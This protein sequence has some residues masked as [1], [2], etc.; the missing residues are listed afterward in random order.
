MT[1]AIPVLLFRVPSTQW[2]TAM[3]W[4]RD[5]LN[6]LYALQRGIYGN[7]AEVIERV[8]RWLTPEQA[9]AF[10]S[11]DRVRVLLSELAD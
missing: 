9:A 3:E 11:D 5:M 10:Y 2:A 6:L 4:S 7:R 8:Q 1:R